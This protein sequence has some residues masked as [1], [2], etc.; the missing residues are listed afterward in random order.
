LSDRSPPDLRQSSIFDILV[1][2]ALVLGIIPSL[3]ALSEGYRETLPG[4]AGLTGPLNPL[5]FLVPILAVFVAVRARAL[6]TGPMKRAILGIGAAWVVGTLGTGIAARAC[7]FPGAFIRE[8]AAITVGLLA[9]FALVLLP[10]KKRGSV[11]IGW[12]AIVF[13][14]AFLDAVFP[15]AI[16]WLYA[17]VF[18]PDTRKLDFAETG[19]RVLTGIYGRQS[20]AK[21]LAWLPWLAFPAFVDR[22]GARKREQA[23]FGGWAAI[24]LLSGVILATSQRG[25][26][27]GAFVALAVFGIHLLRFESLRSRL[28]LGIGGAIVLASLSVA[29]FVPRA[30]VAPRVLGEAASADAK[31][32][33]ILRTSESNAGFRAKMTR[34]SLAAIARAPLGNACLPDSYF[35]SYGLIHGAHSHNLFIE[36]FRSRGWAWGALHLALWIFSG[37][38]FWRTRT[39]RSAAFFAGWCAIVVS[40]LV[41]HPWFVLN[42]SIVLGAY[43]VEGVVS[44]SSSRLANPAPSAASPRVAISGD[45]R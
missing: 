41:D 10:E 20:L 31:S 27:G 11:Y 22:V 13:L 34:A 43:L 29:L 8:W 18:D 44:F 28:A 7:G 1:I 40:G 26:T 16:D 24:A 45:P 35:Q 15:Q 36:Q 9:G 3:T 5:K 4:I 19:I 21:L 39:I 30:I 6:P 38:G 23:I 25:P 32:A 14:S 42:Q 17:H 37:L 12:F 33:E 2:F